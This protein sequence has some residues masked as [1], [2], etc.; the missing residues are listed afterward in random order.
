MISQFE[1]RDKEV[2]DADRATKAERQ[3]LDKEIQRLDA[4]IE[5]LHTKKAV[6][7]DE[8]LSAARSRRD[9]AFELLRG[10][11][12]KGHDVTE[13]T[14]ALLGQGKLID[15]YPRVVRD[16]DEVADRLRGESE[17][18]AKLAQD[19]ENR[20]RL[21]TQVADG[22][23][24][25]RRQQETLTAIESEWRAVWRPV[26]G[27]PP[28]IADAREWRTDFERS[29]KQSEALNE[30]RE[31]LTLLDARIEK[32]V[33]NVRAAMTAL[34]SDTRPPAGLAAT[35]AAADK[36]WQRILKE[37]HARS[38]HARR[39]TENV[40]EAIDAEKAK[41]SAQADV[42]EWQRLWTEATRGLLS[43]DVVPPDDA[44]AA[45]DA[46]E[47]V[48]GA[49]DTA[50]GYDARIKGIDRDAEWFRDN[51]HALASRLGETVEQEEDSW[52]NSVHD[53]LALALQEEERRRQAGERKART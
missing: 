5:T 53:R 32:H 17:H 3:R 33:K 43:G 15:L 12:E 16:A 8:D 9:A 45:L 19:L 47:K 11:W 50:A 24:S 26:L 44:L 49:L 6:P 35:L 29:L 34:E 31:R 22:E 4:M 51:V 30:A 23:T 39:M 2:R 28:S 42:D 10:H 52:V 20:K 46:I 1:T 40:Q 27:T 14:R 37:N 41:R 21:S 18:V 13:K 25:E 7:T 48:R 38:E 36:L